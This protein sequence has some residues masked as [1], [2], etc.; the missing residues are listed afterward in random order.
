MRTIGLCALAAVLVA[1]SVKNA[2]RDFV[3]KC[4]GMIRLVACAGG[5]YML[6]R[7][8]VFH[9]DPYHSVI[10]YV[11][12][13]ETECKSVI[14]DM[15][16]KYPKVFEYDDILGIKRSRLRTSGFF[17]SPNAKLKQ[18][19]PDWDDFRHFLKSLNNVPPFWRNPVP[20]DDIISDFKSRWKQ[21]IIKYG[22]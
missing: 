22:T 16:D 13:S 10:V 17:I 19:I 3:R 1:I 14:Q 6:L 21:T 9:A 7:C 15:C 4:N 18:T 2:F 20:V 11:A 5:S 8:V 12:L